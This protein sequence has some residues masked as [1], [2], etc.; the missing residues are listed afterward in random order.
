MILYLLAIGFVSVLGQVVILRELNVAFYGVELIYILAIAVWL[1][2]TAAGALIG[3]RT[4]VP[5]K[6]TVG[7]LLIGFA[8]LLPADVVLVRGIRVLFGGVPGAYLPFGCGS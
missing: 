5:S 4:Y 1:L 3:R 2:W 6:T 8:V 7:A